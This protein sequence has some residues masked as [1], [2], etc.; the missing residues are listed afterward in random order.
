MDPQRPAD[1]IPV[2]AHLSGAR[3]GT[4]ERLRGAALWLALGDH[5]TVY[6]TSEAAPSSYHAE[7][8]RRGESYELAAAPGRN[9]WVNGERAAH[10]ILASGDV[11]EIGSGGPVIR[12]RL[13][14]VERGTAK[15]VG[16]V[17][18]DCWACARHE[19]G[20]AFQRAAVF[21]AGVPK[22]LATQTSRSV[23]LGLLAALML[24]VAATVVLAGRTVMLER[25]LAEEQAQVSAM[26]TLLEQ[27]RDN[28]TSEAEL[29][30]MLA[31]VRDSIT[32]AT[33]RLGVLEQRSEA[34]SRIIAA[35]TRA[36]VLLLGAYGF[37]DSASG[38]T[39]R[40]TLAPGTAPMPGTN[41]DPSPVTPRQSGPV[42]EVR[43]TGTGFIATSTG[44]ILTNRHVAVPW[45]FDKAAADI[46]AQGYTPVM[47]R[48][49]AYMPGVT[50]PFDVR[51][52][53]VSDDADLALLRGSVVA[54]SL[55][56]LPLSITP[57]RPGEEVI[58]LGYPL[59]IRALMSRTGAS[60]VE[61]L[62]SEG[63]VDF[64]TAAQRLSAR[65]FIAPLASRGIIGQVTAQSVVYDAQTTHG[66][67]GGPVLAATG[68]VVAVNSAVL[69]GFG[70]ANIGVPS[71]QARRLLVLGIALPE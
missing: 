6:A 44:L 46:I 2:I 67:S 70:G 62:L 58:V 45:E 32:A 18:S 42:F 66:G 29:R 19:R 57:V 30:S 64:W 36:T 4:S 15:S 69:A 21:L 3:R 55:V 16:E 5:G 26:A 11:I 60:F 17:F 52:V 63:D 50:A 10:V 14:P 41:G 71:V 59:G 34:P 8:R 1:T 43:Y 28:P 48:F 35:A 53:R 13:Y 23:R 37:V 24:L 31:E 20:G 40:I 25:R 12:F 9:I 22:E 61:Q 47:R 49:I 51:T 7:L 65:G 38:D 54:D 68:E 27:S 33:E 39:L 56:P